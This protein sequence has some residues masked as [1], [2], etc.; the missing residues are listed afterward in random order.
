M[1]Y[2]EDM[3]F[4]RRIGVFS[5]IQ[6]HLGSRVANNMSTSLPNLIVQRTCI[7]QKQKRCDRRTLGNTRIHSSR[8]C[9]LI[10]YDQVSLSSAQ[11][12]VFR[13]PGGHRD[14]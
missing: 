8:L 14:C 6:F 7:D 2:K 4:Q 13:L 12:I 11:Q 3:C 10:I 1:T 5:S 9:Y